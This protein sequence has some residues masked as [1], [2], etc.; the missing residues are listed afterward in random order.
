[1]Y[2]KA[3]CPEQMTLCHTLQITLFLHRLVTASIF[4]SHKHVHVYTALHYCIFS[5]IHS[6]DD[7]DGDDDDD[8]TA[9][10][11]VPHT[12][13]ARGEGRYIFPVKKSVR[14]LTKDKAY[15]SD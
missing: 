15:T 14:P 9:V 2:T 8:R 4:F 3:L 10:G 5:I 11:C 12:P 1:M 6:Y 13:A 7:N